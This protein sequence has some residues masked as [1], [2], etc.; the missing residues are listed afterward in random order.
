VVELG[1]VVGV[2]DFGVGVPTGRV[3]RPAV[4]YVTLNNRGD[5]A[6]YV[7]KTGRIR[8]QWA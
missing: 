5:S 7:K 1:R 8:Q 6:V 3:S 2:R 4:D